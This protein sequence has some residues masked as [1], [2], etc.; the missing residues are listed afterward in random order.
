MSKIPMFFGTHALSAELLREE[1]FENVR[2]DKC[3]EKERTVDLK[4]ISEST[5]S[6]REKTSNSHKSSYFKSKR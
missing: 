1:W 2:T 3:S 5:A 4:E 6:S